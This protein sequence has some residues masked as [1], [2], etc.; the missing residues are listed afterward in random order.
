MS[1]ALSFDLKSKIQVFVWGA[2][3]QKK[4]N[5]V[6]IDLGCRGAKKIERGFD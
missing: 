1:S 6:L 2:G 5:E 4:L 3:G